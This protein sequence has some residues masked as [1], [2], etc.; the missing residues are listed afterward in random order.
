MGD[1]GGAE[2]YCG[3][4]LR[5]AP[6]KVVAGQWMA[7]PVLWAKWSHKGSL[8]A[9]LT[10]HI[11]RLDAERFCKVA[12][13]QE[14]ALPSCRVYARLYSELF[15]ERA[16]QDGS[17]EIDQNLWGTDLGGSFDDIQEIAHIAFEM[18]IERVGSYQ[19]RLMHQ[20]PVLRSRLFSIWRRL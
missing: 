13:C 4:T 17:A 9:D 14:T 3:R 2:Y 7:E 12:R 11:A 5:G 20:A 19:P 15:A 18:P 6:I 10:C 16:R 1:D 8:I